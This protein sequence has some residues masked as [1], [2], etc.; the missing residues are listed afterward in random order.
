M[1]K[2]CKIP[3]YCQNMTQFHILK[4]G[5]ITIYQKK[6]NLLNED[7]QKPKIYG[8]SLMLARYQKNCDNWLRD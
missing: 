1:A 2:C 6:F 8:V 4:F 3:L 7:F 5:F